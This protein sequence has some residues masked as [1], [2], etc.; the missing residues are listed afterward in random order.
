MEGDNNTGFLS[1]L[2]RNIPQG[3]R[4]RSGENLS[5][6]INQNL[7]EQQASGLRENSG[8]GAISNRPFLGPGSGRGSHSRLIR[9]ITEGN[10]EAFEALLNIMPQTEEIR[11]VLLG[12]SSNMK[13]VIT[14]L[15]NSMEKSHPMLQILE[16]AQDMTGM[17]ERSAEEAE[18]REVV[19]DEDTKHTNTTEETKHTGLLETVGRSLGITDGGTRDL[20]GDG[21]VDK[22]DLA[23]SGNAD[24]VSN[25]TINPLIAK[26]LTSGKSSGR[27]I[28]R[29]SIAPE[30]HTKRSNQVNLVQQGLAGHHKDVN[31]FNVTF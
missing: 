31:L 13:D 20:D 21:D 2:R 15:N 18:I 11:K 30:M 12:A 17:E 23:L 29:A 7:A 10:P 5:S 27:R 14:A 19:G 3:M 4:R 24:A 22:V 25:L 6:S 9:A 26:F 1:D 28:A 8:V 16:S